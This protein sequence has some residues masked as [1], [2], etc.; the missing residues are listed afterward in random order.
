MKK[1]HLKDVADIYSGATPLTRNNKFYED[2]NI[3]WITP[4]DLS[5]YRHK[6]IMS[7]K[8]NITKEGYQSCAT[9][10]LPRGAVLLSTRAPIGYVAIAGKE[11]C[12]NQGFKSFVCKDDILYFQYLYYYLLHNRK[13]IEALGNGSTFKEV[14]RNTLEDFE[15]ELPSIDVQKHIVKDLEI[16]D[17]KYENNCELLINIEHFIEKLY[18]KLFEDTKKIYECTPL[19]DLVD[20]VTGGTPSTKEDI[21]WNNGIYYWYTPTD[22]TDNNSLLSLSAQRKI[23]V[24][25]LANCGAKLIPAYSVIMTSRATV[26]EAVINLNEAT[27][28]QGILSIIPK[29][30]RITTLQL[31][32]WIKRNKKLIVSIAN[33]STFKEI[34]KKDF[35]KLSINVQDES[36]KMFT[37]ETEKLFHLYE[38]LVLENNLICELKEKLLLTKF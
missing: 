22:V 38:S 10:L 27:T 1:Y 36:R 35:E 32:F 13:K 9:N 26:G 23:S 6:Y 17:E 16:L 18:C 5:G 19:G 8:R 34:Y 3:S 29:D 28:N 11:L 2:G 4:K 25:G 37:Q 33:G 15:I 14:S 12:T 24:S 30:K 7:G 20:I 31:Y 21:Y